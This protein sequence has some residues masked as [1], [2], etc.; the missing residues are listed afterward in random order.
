MAVLTEYM[1]PEHEGGLL[2]ESIRKFCKMP[3]SGKKIPGL[4]EKM[5]NYDNDESLELQK[6]RLIAY[7]KSL[8][9]ASAKFKIYAG[10]SATQLY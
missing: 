6:Q 7:L 2:D 9:L 1:P 5:I 8:G 3:V 10:D 4:A